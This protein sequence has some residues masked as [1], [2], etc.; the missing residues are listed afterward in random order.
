[1][2]ID[3]LGVIMLIVAELSVITLSVTM[4][5]YMLGVI[6]MSVTLQISFC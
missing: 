4:L 2:L 1:M 6:M 5:R 3:M